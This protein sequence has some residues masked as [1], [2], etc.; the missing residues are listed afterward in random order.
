MMKNCLTPGTSRLRVLM[1]LAFCWLPA[2]IAGHSC[3]LRA[4]PA[5]KD[6]VVRNHTFKAS[7]GVE[8]GVTLY[9]PRAPGTY[10][11]VIFGHG[12]GQSRF[13][14]QGQTRGAT[15]SSWTS[16]PSQARWYTQ[17][18]YVVLAVDSRYEKLLDP[19]DPA[20]P[21][22]DV[23]LKP[24]GQA[25]LNN[26]REI[27]DHME[28]IDWL[29]RD[30]EGLIRP[31]KVDPDRIGMSGY[32]YEANQ[33]LLTAAHDA[34]LK[35][36]A[37]LS[38]WV[39]Y[40][41]VKFP[42]L[43]GMQRGVPEFFQLAAPLVS[44]DF[45][46]NEGRGNIDPTWFEIFLQ[47]LDQRLQLTDLWFRKASLSWQH[48]RMQSAVFLA[49]AWNE[50]LIPADQAIGLFTKLAVPKKLYVGGWGHFPTE[51][52]P[53]EGRHVLELRKRF[54]DYWLKGV[55]NGI[56]DT[57]VELALVPWNA[58]K[59]SGAVKTARYNR[60]PM[61]E[62]RYHRLYLR[63]DGRLLPEAPSS[64]ESPDTLVRRPDP[65]Q[66]RLLAEA[67]SE[68]DRGLNEG[69]TAE[70]VRSL[71]K[72]FS[73]GAGHAWS[74]EIP[75]GAGAVTYVSEPLAADW[76]VLGAAHLDVLLEN[77]GLDPVKHN[78]ALVVRWLA[79]PPGPGPL[80]DLPKTRAGEVLVTYG[81]YGIES[82]ESRT[83]P[84]RANWVHVSVPMMPTN[85]LIPRGSK[86]VL[87]V[88][89][90]DFPNTF[91]CLS[92]STTQLHHSPTA[93]GNEGFEAGYP[94][95]SYAAFPVLPEQNAPRPKP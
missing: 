60:L 85:V 86:L 54:F 65:E 16:V 82:V 14:D 56:M 34:R 33:T 24:G 89:G 87:R 46:D 6:I 95:L 13:E 22:D 12:F 3:L 51:A 81:F 73:L 45:K 76:H 23:Y 52:N 21:N 92:E 17:E 71:R 67:R 30:S 20:N 7:D 26:S 36:I 55:R 1:L 72:L 42:G 5:T 38:G 69:L 53:E 62:V 57:P 84:D 44:S 75:V 10:P 37:V 88:T 50:F 59:S 18:G 90:C 29:I 43:S 49:Q 58:N 63:S 74:P 4:Q 48:H 2:Q 9:K 11:A 83:R 94:G 66:V 40:L 93:H 15:A 70:H 61:D 64:A 91:P 68:L 35:A 39:D 41:P 78:N 27:R 25:G 47:I 28:E 19:G 79:I 31:A 8:I 32:S 77:Q 80:Q